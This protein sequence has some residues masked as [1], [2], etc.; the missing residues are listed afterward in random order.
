MV[1]G[2]APDLDALEV[3]L[4]RVRVPVHPVDRAEDDR[5]AG[6]VVVVVEGERPP[7]PLNTSTG[8]VVRLPLST[9]T[10]TVVVTV[11]GLG[12]G[13]DRGPLGVAAPTRVV[14]VT[15][16]VLVRTT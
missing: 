12:R 16:A 15:L 13:R 7:P 6:V 10:G 14:V 2:L 11:G 8:T 4:D 3:A 1:V 9:S 5:P